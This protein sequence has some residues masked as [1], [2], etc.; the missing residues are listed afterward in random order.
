MAFQYLNWACKKDGA[1]FLAGLVTAV[2]EIMILNKKKKGAF[3]IHLEKASYGENGEAVE[4]VA[5][6]SGRCPILGNIMVRLDRALSK[7][8]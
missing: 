5:Q 1:N 3:T 6:G 8:V 7:L 4:Q 2:Q